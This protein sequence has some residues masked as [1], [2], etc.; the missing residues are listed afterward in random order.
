MNLLEVRD[1]MI[2]DGILGDC[3]TPGFMGS[4]RMV[5]F[6][7]KLKK[8]EKEQEKIEDQKKASEIIDIN[9][10]FN[11]KN[12]NKT[13]IDADTIWIETMGR[14]P[15]TNFILFV[16]N[17][18]PIT[19]LEKW[20][21]KNATIHEFPNLSVRDMIAYIETHL[22]IPYEQAEKMV[23]RLGNN[24]DFVVQ[25]T[26]KLSLAYQPKWSDD[27]LK[28]I[29]PDYRDENAFNMLD[30][31]WNRDHK[32]MIKI[33]TRL[34]ETADHELTMA[35]MI[36]MIRKILIS[37]IFP[38][39]SNLPITP[40]QRNTGK[41]LLPHKQTLRKLYDDIVAVDIAEKRGELPHKTNAFLMALLSFC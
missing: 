34:M 15:E 6:H 5:I 31:L 30:P 1:D 8:T 19:E 14:I 21:E 28:S 7:E 35:M 11:N 29:L 36:T 33:W 27:E 3:L 24:Y 13:P 18:K 20:L 23:D 25:E 26:K 2:F 12:D 4:T 40:G 16:G 17:K 32:S 38:R 37:T 41:R 10:V 9:D 22:R 39:I